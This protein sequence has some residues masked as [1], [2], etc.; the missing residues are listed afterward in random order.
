MRSIIIRIRRIIPDGRSIV[1]DFGLR[2]KIFFF[3]GKELANIEVLPF[4]NVSSLKVDE[5]RDLYISIV[6]HINREILFWSPHS[7][8]TQTLVTNPFIVVVVV[9]GGCYDAL[10]WLRV[11]RE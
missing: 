7:A 9:Y 4:E 2:V 1:V 6:L 10:M 8:K 11:E 5:E 3:L